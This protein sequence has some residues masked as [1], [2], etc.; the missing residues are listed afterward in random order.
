M[1]IYEQ[2]SDGISLFLAIV[3]F[4]ITMLMIAAMVCFFPLLKK[5]VGIIVNLFHHRAEMDTKSELFAVLITAA[6]YLALLLGSVLCIHN[7]I[8]YSRYYVSMR[9]PLSRSG[10]YVVLGSEMIEY[11][12]DTLGYGVK[13]SMGGEE[14]V[15]ELPPGLNSDSL[16]LLTEGTEATIYYQTVD[17]VNIIVRIVIP[18]Q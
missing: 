18:S 5:S 1:V 4:I 7:T 17:H 11:R 6:I 12:G 2:T 3:L 15:V 14:F 10:E 13:I 16:K 8:V 9:N